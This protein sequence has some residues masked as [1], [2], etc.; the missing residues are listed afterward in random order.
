MPGLITDAQYSG[1]PLPLP[2]RVSAGIDVTDLCGKTRMYSRPS[3]R[4]NCA[5]V[6]RPASIASALS[7]PPSNDCRPNSPCDTKLPRQALPLTRPRWLLRYL[8]RLGICGI[9]RI[10]RQ[11]VAVVHPD[12]D[13]DVALCGRGLGEA[14]FHLGAERRERD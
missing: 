3:P 13:A 10:L 4:R 9:G 12:L 6:T 14:V 7:Q 2:M 8:T 1:S 5:T 11:I